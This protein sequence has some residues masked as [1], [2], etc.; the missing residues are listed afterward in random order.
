MSRKQINIPQV[1]R[2]EI[3]GKSFPINAELRINSKKSIT[4]EDSSS[5]RNLKFSIITRTDVRSP[6]FSRTSLNQ[7]LFRS[8][9]CL[10]VWRCFRNISLQSLQTSNT[11]LECAR[12]ASQGTSI[13]CL[14][15]HHQATSI[16]R[17][18]YLEFLKVI[19]HD[20]YNIAFHTFIRFELETKS[21]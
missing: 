13:S 11:L 7:L 16:K 21:Y 5:L 3:K 2:S 19:M 6:C 8:R 4:A 10:L 18:G 15:H 12:A 1:I 17:P 20:N 14:N 9:I